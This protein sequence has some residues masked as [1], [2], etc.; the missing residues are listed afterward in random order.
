M[1]KLILLSFFLIFS[2]NS[3]GEWT[4]VLP[5]NSSSLYIDFK[6]LKV[7]DE[8]I[9]WWYM[10][11]WNEGSAKSYAQGDCDLKGFRVMK[12]IDFSL[13]MGNGEGV[14]KDM[15]TSWEYYQ[16]NSG[17][18]I[19][20][21][22]ICQMSK[23]SPQ[24]QELRIEALAK[25]NDEYEKERNEFLKESEKENSPQLKVL[26]SSYMD[27]IDSKIK[28]FWRYED[29][30]VNW[31]CVVLINQAKN[32]AVEAVKILGCDIGNNE[33]PGMSK[34]KAQEFAKSIRRAV[35]KSSPLPPAPDDSV[36]NKEIIFTFTVN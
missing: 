22:F 29:A 20:L 23:L 32:G 7:N 17:Y 5:G 33:N 6:T 14:D 21:N 10:D 24:D 19:L 35:F 13:P 3:Y 30:Q 15:A 18:E 36:F 9:N 31:S 27:S 4:K 26:K 16:P 8:Y 25:G 2:V 28:S 11:S 34:S 1:K 12:R